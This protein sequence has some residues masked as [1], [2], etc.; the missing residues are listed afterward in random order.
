MKCDDG[1]SAPILSLDLPKDQIVH[2]TEPVAT[3]SS[4]AN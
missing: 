4:S 3:S 1:G 2:K